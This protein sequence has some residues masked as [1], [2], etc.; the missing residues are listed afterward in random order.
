VTTVPGYDRS[1]PFADRDPGPMLARLVPVMDQLAAD[2]AGTDVHVVVTDAY[3][4]VLGGPTSGSSVRHMVEAP[5]LDPVELTRHGLMSAGA[6]VRDL[7]TGEHIG[8]VT[9]VCPASA[10]NPLLLP[11]ARRAAHDCALRL[12]EGCSA[13]DGLL[14]EEFLRVRRRG[15]APLIVVGE[16]TLRAN[17]AAAALVGPFDRERLWHAARDV[18]EQGR[19]ELDFMVGD[20]ATTV[21]ATVMAVHDRQD[22]AGFVLR[23]RSVEAPNAA[24]AVKRPP[25][26]WGSLTA[27]ERTLAS[28]VG[29][30]LTN[31]E[32]AA[33]L[34]VSP[35]TVDSHLRHIFRKLDINS[36]VE[37]AALVARQRDYERVSA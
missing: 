26:G 21:T 5:R 18:V 9:L 37:L 17:A 6:P 32:A 14:E 23:L 19:S 10:A 33:R 30:G 22:V 36:R 11:F 20:A 27:T 24:T 4:N 7:R 35:H 13:R 34:F 12:L 1:L 8:M 16:R 3:G 2:L 15:R 25:L 31:K 28:I 29:Q